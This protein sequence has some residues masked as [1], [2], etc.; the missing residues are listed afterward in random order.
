MKHCVYILVILFT[1]LACSTSQNTVA[2]N[3]NGAVNDTI[4][5]AN[6]SLEY[7]VVIIDNGFS[8]WLNSRAF[9]RN[10]HSQSFLENKNI[11]YVTEWNSR[12][13][14]PMS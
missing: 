11:M 12:V 14:Q 6:D 1:I 7:E 8:M 3:K 13:L 4:R 10:Y 2:V 9:P 5:I